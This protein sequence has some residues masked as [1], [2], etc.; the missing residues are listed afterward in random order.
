MSKYSYM[1]NTVHTDVVGNKWP[2]KNGGTVDF[3]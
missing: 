3:P 1:H 2:S